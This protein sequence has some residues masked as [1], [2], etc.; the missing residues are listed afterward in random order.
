MK[1]FIYFLIILFITSIS[2]VPAADYGFEAWVTDVVDGDTFKFTTELLGARQRGTCRMLG[3]NAPEKKEDEEIYL[4]SKGELY[5]LIGHRKVLIRTDGRDSFGRWLCW[6]IHDGAD[7][8]AIMR[9]GLADYP[10]R[11]KYE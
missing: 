11:D 8:N 5:S 6:V 1:R 4:R 10:G 7:I 9:T 2:P 3:Y